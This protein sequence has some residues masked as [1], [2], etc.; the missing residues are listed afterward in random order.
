MSEGDF[1]T[2]LQTRPR[3]SNRRLFRVSDAWINLAFVAKIEV[4]PAMVGT[5]WSEDELRPRMYVQFLTNNGV[6]I[7]ERMAVDAGYAD[8]AACTAA[9]VAAL[10]A[11]DG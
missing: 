11:F 10:E 2:G 7:T 4:W 3:P 8:M 1:D 5:S 9:L 6:E